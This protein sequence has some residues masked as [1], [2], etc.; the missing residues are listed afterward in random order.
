MFIV[1]CSADVVRRNPLEA[2]TMM[3]QRG[4]I[5]AQRERLLLYV[6]IT[7]ARELLW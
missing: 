7:R 6:A 1:G 5:D 3:W 2:V 4:R